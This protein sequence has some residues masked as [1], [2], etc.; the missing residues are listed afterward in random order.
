MK[1]KRISRFFKGVLIVFLTLFLLFCGELFRSNY[2]I[3]VTRYSVSDAAI[4]APIRIVFFADLH[5]R[6]FGVRNYRLLD[7]IAAQEPDL[8]CMVGDLF[9]SDADEA[10]V[11]RVCGMIRDAVSIAP[12]YFSLGNQEFDYAQ[13]RGDYLVQRVKETGAVVLDNEYLDLNINGTEICLGGYMGYY[14]N[15]HMMV[16]D[17]AQQHLE[18]V[19]IWEF[20]QSDRYKILLNHIVTQW[21][22]WGAIDRNP[23]DLV[24]SGHY[25]GGVV[26]N[27]FTDQGLF[28]PYIGW[29]PP[30]TK[31]LFA[32]KTATCVLTTGMAGSYGIPRF[33]NPPE[34]CVVDFLPSD[35]GN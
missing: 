24:L 16:S 25:H 14:K 1:K 35:G 5:G 13:D 31:G 26:R 10:E 22:D 34:I 15:P 30:Y 20:E 6:E 33:F 27:P 9:N 29:F 12:V 4:Q 18:S 28:A 2:T 17:P 23:V 11:D 21:V 8:I 7:K 3:S 32:G 19:F